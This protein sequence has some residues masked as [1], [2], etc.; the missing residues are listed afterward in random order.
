MTGL[1]G[2]I[3]MRVLVIIG[4]LL[5]SPAAKAEFQLSIFGGFNTASSGDVTL[6]QG[7][8]SGTYDV[9]WF[10]ESFEVPPFYGVRGAYWLSGLD[11][12]SWG[13]AVD[14]THA[15]VAADLSN[16]ALA[17]AFS[18]L[19]FTDGLNT[20]TLNALYRMNANNRLT[21]YA[22]AGAGVA[23]PHVEVET[24]PSVGKTFDYQLTGPAAQALIG[25]DIKLGYGFSLFG[26]YKANYSWNAADLVGGGSLET[27]ILA[28]HFATG[29]SLAFGAPPGSR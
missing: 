14:F 3:A 23:F 27:D 28:H 1:R 4:F 29:I 16:P 6:T 20:A 19:E 11:L 7:A 25:A 9:D 8:L 17:G 24:V 5:A 13:L 18:S 26:E 12:A 2:E 15:K 22:G 10:G 21:L